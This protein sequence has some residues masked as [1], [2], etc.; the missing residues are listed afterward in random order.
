MGEILKKAAIG[1]KP[2]WVLTIAALVLVF[3]GFICPPLADI[4]N[5]VIIAVGELIG[6]GAVWA[7]VKAIDKGT[8]SS[9]QHG[10][11]TLKIGKG[12]TENSPHN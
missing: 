8:P 11:T 10:Q 5:S 7:F 1:N 9:I 4:N 2:F 12:D 6:L 3:A